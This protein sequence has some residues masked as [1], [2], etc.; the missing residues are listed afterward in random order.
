[1]FNVIVLIVNVVRL[2]VDWKACIQDWSRKPEDEQQI[3][4]DKH[5]RAIFIKVSVDNCDCSPSVEFFE[6]YTSSLSSCDCYTLL[7]LQMQMQLQV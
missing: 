7:S 2:S 3:D 1:M 6:H 4:D 5:R